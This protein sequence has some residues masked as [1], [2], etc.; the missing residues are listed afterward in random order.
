MS[1]PVA[2]PP[3]TQRLDV[4]SLM[5]W[6]GRTRL[7]RWLLMSWTFA[8]SKWIHI[9]IFLVVNAVVGS[10][11]IWMPILA[12]VARPDI[13]SMVEL[14]KQLAASGPYIFAVAYL[15]GSTS[16]VAYEYL[17]EQVTSN[18]KTKTALAVCAFVII[19]ICTLLSALQTSPVASTL[20]PPSTAA[21]LAQ[22]AYV[23]EAARTLNASEYAQLFITAI[24]VVVGLLMYVISRFD[25]EDIKQAIANFSA[26][27]EADSKQLS[28]D[29]KKITDPELNL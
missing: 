7:V 25:D 15:A 18:R 12:A 13:N 26:K 4:R 3:R 24:A 2:N 14:Q 9:F 10:I 5:A 23:K 21:Y 29:A 6:A 22:G 28:E 8:R 20:A 19:I 27:T 16:F 17:D 1:D 11:G